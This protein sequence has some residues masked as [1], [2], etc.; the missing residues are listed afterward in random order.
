MI[1]ESPD[2]SRALLGR[3]KQYRTGMYTCLSGFIEQVPPQSVPPRPA[4]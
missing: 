2:G 1:V 4:L 3:T